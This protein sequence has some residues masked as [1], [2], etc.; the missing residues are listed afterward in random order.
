MLKESMTI[1]SLLPVAVASP[2][3]PSSFKK[4]SKAA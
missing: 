1:S 2:G 4:A 3:T